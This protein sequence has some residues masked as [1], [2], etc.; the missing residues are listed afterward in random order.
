MSRE[1][2]RKEENLG[3]VEQYFWFLS[4]RRYYLRSCFGVGFLGGGIVKTLPYQVK[5]TGQS[6]LCRPG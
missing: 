6:S 2:R 4:G 5:P 1:E 3:K